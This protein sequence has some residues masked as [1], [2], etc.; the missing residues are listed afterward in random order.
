M[1]FACEHDLRGSNN[2]CSCSLFNPGDMIMR[3]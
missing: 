1:N 2:N 3:S